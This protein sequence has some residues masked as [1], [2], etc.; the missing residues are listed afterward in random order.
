MALTRSATS[1]SLVGLVREVEDAGSVGH[2]VPDSGDA[3][4][5][6]VIVGAR[7]GNLHRG[8]PENPLRCRVRAPSPRATLQACARDGRPSGRAV[9]RRALAY[10]RRRARAAPRSPPW[11]ASNPSSS[12]KRRSKTARQ[13]SATH[14]V[15][16]PST[17][18]PPMMPL[19]FS[20]ACRAAVRHH[21]HRRRPR[22]EGR[23]QFAPDRGRESRPCARSR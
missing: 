15:W 14:G 4:D 6:L 7:A 2:A 18:C 11:F 10:R 16:I 8:P 5:V 9:R 19:M 1:H 20:V 21:R 13:R 3:V 12:R 22:R 23:H 17:G